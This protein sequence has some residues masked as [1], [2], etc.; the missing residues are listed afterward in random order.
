[1]L[2][3]PSASMAEFTS[4]PSVS[5]KIS[6]TTSQS[7][8]FRTMS[9]PHERDISMRCALPSAPMTVLA[10]SSRAPAAAQSPIGPCA[11]T[12]TVSPM[13]MLAFSAPLN[14]VDMI[15]G[16]ISTCSSLKL[17]GTGARLA[18]ASGT[19]RYSAWAP[20]IMLPNRH[21]A[22]ARYPWHPH[23]PLATR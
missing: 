9:A 20:S 1:M 3:C 11:N 19:S 21:P 14:P 17:S 2:C 16:H 8:K 6:S 13:R 7:W 15:S 4:L 18:C 10:P 12:A 23:M 22:V 5:R